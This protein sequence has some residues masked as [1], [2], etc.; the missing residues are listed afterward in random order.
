MFFKKFKKASITLLLSLFIIPTSVF[1]Y[2]SYLIPGGENIG[3][4]IETSGVIVVGTYEVNGKNPAIDAGIKMGDIITKVNGNSI[5]TID[6]MV[7]NLNGSDDTIV[8][9]SYK[10][11]GEIKSTKL[12][13]FKDENNIYQTGL[14]VKDSITGIGTLR[15]W[16]SRKEYRCF[17]RY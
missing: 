11:D 6:E 4:Q 5:T 9:I 1:A 14:Y 17:I 16:N 13:I 15:S 7:S 10:R 3:I 2:S 12:E 8:T